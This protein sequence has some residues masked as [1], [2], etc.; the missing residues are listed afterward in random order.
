M[1]TKKLF[2]VAAIF[3]GIFF[4]AVTILP[5]AVAQAEPVPAEVSCL[6]APTG[7]GVNL[8]LNRPAIASSF[9]GFDATYCPIGD[10]CTAD[11]AVDGDLMTRWSSGWSDDEWIYVDLGLP[12]NIEGVTLYWEA[13]FG[14]D[15]EIQVSNNAIT[16]T[17]VYAASGGNGG[18]DEIAGLSATGQYVRMY[19]LARGSQYGYSLYEFE[20]YGC[21]ST[22]VDDFESG[23]P[24]TMDSHGYESGFRTWTDGSGSSVTITT[25]MAVF[26]SGS[27]LVLPGQEVVT[28]TILTADQTI[29]SGGWGG[30]AHAFAGPQ[31]WSS[32]AGVS[33]WYKGVASDGPVNVYILDNRASDAVTDTAER[34]GYD[35]DASTTWQ[36][37]NVP[38]S[39]LV[40]L[41]NIGQPS[42]APNDGLGLTEMWGY[43]IG[44][45]PG[46]GVVYVDDV[47]LIGQY[48][49]IDD[50]DTVEAYTWGDTGGNVTLASTE[51]L[52]DSALALPG[53]TGPN[54]VLAV[55]YDIAQWGGFS[56]D[57]SATEDWSGHDGLG[58]WFYGNN[59]RHEIQVEIRDAS[60]GGTELFV[61][62]FTDVFTGWQYISLPWASFGPRL[63]HPTLPPIDGILDL[64]N[65]SGYA[66]LLPTGSSSFYMDQ[67]GV[68]GSPGGCYAEPKVDFASTI[69][70]VTEGDTAAITVTVNTTLTAPIMVSY[71][72]ADGT[73]A[74]GSDYVAVT[75]TITFEP[76]DTPQ[77]VKTFDVV[78]IDNGDTKGAKTLVLTLFDP[79]GAEIGDNS[80]ATLI[81]QDD[82]VM[83]YQNPNLSIS[84]RVEDLIGRMT[85]AE[86][87]GQM[88]QLEKGALGAGDENIV[89]YFLGSVLSGGGGGPASGNYPEDWADMYD[90]YQ[91]L[92]LS[93]RLGIPLIYGV[94]AVHGH[95]NV[96]SA[97]IF[98]H[99]IGLG[100]TWNPALVEETGRLTAIEVAAT[101]V[102][103]TFAP[104]VAVARDERWGRTYESFGETP[105][106]ASMM[107]TIVNG[108]QGPDLAARD[109]V[110]ATVKHY[111]GDGG[112][113]D[114]I[115]QGNTEVTEAELRAIH[116]PPYV[117][118]IAAGVG[119]IMPSYSSWNGDKMHGHT[120]LISDVLKGELGF[121]GFTISDWAAIDQLPGD[122]NSDVSTSINAGLDMVMVPSN[123][124]GFITAMMAEYAAGNI[125][126]E[127]ID[128]AVRRILTKKFELGLFENP[129][130]DRTNIGLV[131]SQEHRDVARQAVRESLV[132]LKNENNLLP[133]PADLNAVVVAGKNADDMGNQCGGW[134]ISWQ[135]SSGDITPGTTILE[136]IQAIVSATTVVTHVSG[137]ALLPP[138]ADVGIVI[139]GETPY[140]EG[141]GYDADL[142][143]D[144]D[145]INTIN[146]VCDAMDCVVVLVS[147]RPLIVTDEISRANAFVAAWLPGTEGDGVAEVLFGDYGF[148]GKLSMSWPRSVDQLPINFGDAEYDPLYPYGYGLR[149]P[150]VDFGA[151]AYS[152]DEGGAVTITVTLNTTA[153]MPVTVSYTTED[154][155][156]LAGS[157]YITATGTITFA[158][159][160][161]PSSSKTFVVETLEDYEVEYNETVTLAFSDATGIRS[162]SPATLSILDNDVELVEFFIYLPVVMRD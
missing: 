27:T 127:R 79:V 31:N 140:A 130:A 58:F 92:A 68:F 19:G 11:L 97:T 13:A 75:G 136:G 121:D 8:A 88:T 1:K 2:V 10:G 9:Q 23:L 63:D 30:F 153:T 50:F 144:E 60:A 84:Q 42:G 89:K 118:A 142:V 124:E 62:P 86:K 18:T 123:G 139:V 93:T 155:T 16:W 94:D 122:Y 154:G 7:Q 26:G 12:A 101:G 134:T 65:T 5:M 125:S 4:G 80:P 46:S 126:I 43:G 38:F 152:V 156:A 104:C 131:G 55:T 100:A 24:Y 20:V 85:L 96:Y 81:I 135:G 110:L 59:S 137:T 149:Y 162:G 82:E 151:P 117:D 15:Y 143:L 103:W 157:D 69:Y 138:A 113:T 48:D 90:H 77:T 54:D 41:D 115:D 159:G 74:A 102:D 67:I 98:P 160:S 32:F 36:H 25:T 33:F 107:A 119:S 141:Y 147:G 64:T 66:F 99:N 158:A 56:Y 87:I 22:V 120:Y 29:V 6:L 76:G 78:T 116:L 44:F 39:A 14:S 71:A 35:F 105:E 148:T 73:A 95:S 3:L 129:Y 108:Y 145:D 17:T 52:S 133:L 40:R 53:Q 109:A 150:G 57:P 47:Q 132:L 128:D 91:S 45:A 37:I 34:F 111:V 161:L 106:I 70:H 72:T 61:A 28:N 49:V 112:T 114:G 51:I 83:P 21:P 146:N